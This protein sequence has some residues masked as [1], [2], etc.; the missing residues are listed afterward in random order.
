MLTVSTHLALSLVLAKRDTEELVSI[1]QVRTSAL[2]RLFRVTKIVML[3]YS[4]RV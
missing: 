4:N 1:A 3:K 2:S